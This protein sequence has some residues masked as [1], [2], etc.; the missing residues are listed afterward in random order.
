MSA[1][2]VLHRLSKRT[3]AEFPDASQY[4][5]AYETVLDKISGMIT[6]RS[7]IN[8]K[9]AETIIQDLC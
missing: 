2:D 4:C 1:T 7:R 5:A 6:S 9:L 8:S 3:M